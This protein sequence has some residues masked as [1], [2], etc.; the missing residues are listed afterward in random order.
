MPFAQTDGNRNQNRLPQ[1]DENRQGGRGSIEHEG[2][3]LSEDEGLLATM[4]VLEQARN[5]LG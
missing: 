1:D 4:K 5:K 3:R 2:G